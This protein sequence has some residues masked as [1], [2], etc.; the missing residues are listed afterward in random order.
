MSN[1]RNKAT[2]APV[3]EIYTGNQMLAFARNKRGYIALRNDDFDYKLNN[4][5]T[6]LPE[7]TYCDI[8]SGEK[9][10]GKCTGS[11]IQV[12]SKGKTL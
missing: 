5:N 10:N 11:S 6:T 9:A 2:G 1:F 7:G 8:I 3:V 12:D 4:V